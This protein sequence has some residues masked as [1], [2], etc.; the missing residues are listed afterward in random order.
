MVTA[1]ATA[2]RRSRSAWSAT[3]RTSCPSSSGAAVCPT[4]SPIRPRPTTRSTATSRS[5]Y[6]RRGAG[7]ASIGSRRLRAAI[8]GRHGRPRPRDAR[9][10]ARRA[11]ASTTATTSARRARRRR[12]ERLRLPG[13]RPG[14]HPAA[15][16]RGQ[17]PVPLGRAVR[18]SGGHR[19]HRP[20]ARAVPRRRRLHRWI[21]LA[22]E[23]V[24]SR[25]CPR[26]SAGSATASGP[27]AGAAINELVRGRG[28]GADRHRPRPP[29]LR[30]GGLA[31]PRDGRNGDG[32]DAIA[33]W[34]I[35]NALVNTAA[36]AS[37]VSVH[38]GG[39]VGIGYSLHA[40]MVVVADGTRT[41]PPPRARADQPTRAWASS[42]TWTR[43]TR[44]R[45]SSRASAAS[46]SP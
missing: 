19:A 13:L 3:R 9:A 4:S 40:G 27:G 43:A 8:D 26:A 46:A 37:W 2:A 38:H 10:A 45:S 16:L 5:A 41:R 6:A 18:R 25:A 28:Q 44:K 35:L 23:K 15:V 42:A 31:V 29:R 12:R 32:S 24:H 39:G 7:T 22:A 1:G 20:G 30:L 14:I 34:P 17:G 21:E 36:G 11:Y 33:D